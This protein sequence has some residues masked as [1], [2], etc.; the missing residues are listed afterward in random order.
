[1]SR[2]G[3]YITKPDAFLAAMKQVE[4]G[5]F[6]QID[7]DAFGWLPSEIQPIEGFEPGK[8]FYHCKNC[9]ERFI[10]M[11]QEI[12]NKFPNCCDAHR[13]LKNQS[14][15]KKSDYEKLPSMLANTLA[16]TW[17][18]VETNIDN[19]KNWFKLITDY[20]EIAIKS[21]GQFPSGF[22]S[23]L[24]AANY[25]EFV[26]KMFEP[27]LIEDEIK[28]NKLA[29]WLIDRE[30]PPSEDRSVDLNILLHIYRQWLKEFPFEIS[31]LSDLKPYFERQ[32]PVIESISEPNLY[33]GMIAAKIQTKEGLLQW[34]LKI[35]DDILREVNGLKL[36]EAGK[37]TDTAKHTLELVNAQ[38]RQKLKVGYTNA[39]PD[40]DK[41]YRRILKEWLRDEVAYAKEL[42][43]ILAE[44]PQSQEEKSIVNQSVGA[45]KE[46][47]FCRA[48]PVSAALEHFRKLVTNNSM[49]GKPYLTEQALNAFIQRA[50]YGD[51]NVAKQTINFNPAKERGIIIALFHQFYTIGCNEWEPNTQCQQKYVKLL[52]DNF[53]GWDLNKVKNNFTKRPKRT[54]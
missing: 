50:F 18:C 31:F 20:I 4:C 28:R 38:R 48:M 24:G 36:Y 42:K 6:G 11:G 32:F 17:H 12:L 7:A 53:N 41:R 3:F 23:Q 33:N 49:N 47:S 19:D 9:H 43:K 10:L 8:H 26:G 39:S 15:F 21:F 40:A 45:Q 44:Q 22:G 51:A 37:L 5:E 54:I 25:V 35:T 16:Y 34:L 46:N 27:G 2:E 29:N 1:M 52:V 30:Q 14:W 13:K